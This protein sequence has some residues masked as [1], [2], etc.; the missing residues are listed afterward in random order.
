[1]KGAD[2]LRQYVAPFCR[3]MSEAMSMDSGDTVMKNPAL[4]T[5]LAPSKTFI[6]AGSCRWLVL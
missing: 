3:A 5:T 1:M 4:Y 2:R 6:C